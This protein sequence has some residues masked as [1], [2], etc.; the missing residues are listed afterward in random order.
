MSI[1][2]RQ[3]EEQERQR[4]ILVTNQRE[5]ELIEELNR[6][7]LEEAERLRILK[8]RDEESQAYEHYIQGDVD[9]TGVTDQE[10]EEQCEILFA[11]APIKFVARKGE[12]VD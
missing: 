12:K 3:A 5:E 2:R 11:E 9:Y 10:I 8:K 4:L 7:E 1:K 6:I